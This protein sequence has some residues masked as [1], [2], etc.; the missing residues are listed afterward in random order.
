MTEA[1]TLV[2]HRDAL[3]HIVGEPD[4]RGVYTA[5]CGKLLLRTG[6][7]SPRGISVPCPECPR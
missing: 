1:S 4:D 2:G 3:R 6:N 5:R 7:K